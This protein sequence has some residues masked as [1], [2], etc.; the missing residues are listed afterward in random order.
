MTRFESHS[1]R[2]AIRSKLARG[3]MVVL[4]LAAGWVVAAPSARAGDLFC[5][6]PRVYIVDSAPATTQ[7]VVVRQVV[8]QVDPCAPAKTAPATKEVTASP[9]AGTKAA[10]ATPQSTTRSTTAPAATNQVVKIRYVYRDVT[11]DPATTATTATLVRA[12]PVKSCKVVKA[13]PVQT[14]TVRSVQTT[15]AVLVKPRHCWGW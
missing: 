11:P 13:V 4:I 1:D 2:S 7:R 8:R 9:Q 5:H 10:T 6:K 3:A 12:V 14:V 15:Q